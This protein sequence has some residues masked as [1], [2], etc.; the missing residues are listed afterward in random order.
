MT[1]ILLSLKIILIYCAEGKLNDPGAMVLIKLELKSI[2]T[3]VAAGKLKAHEGTVVILLDSKSTNTAV[4]KGKLS[5][6][7][8][9]IDEILFRVRSMYT[10]LAQR[11]LN[12]VAEGTTLILLSVSMICTLPTAEG[13]LK[14]ELL[15]KSLMLLFH[16]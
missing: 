7:V 1:E 10:N 12:T 13:K 11:K 5:W 15:G 4:A 2:L 3:V 16:R 8:Q 9:G 14:T 6:D